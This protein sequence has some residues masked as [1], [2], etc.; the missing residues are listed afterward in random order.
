M[1]HEIK[2]A[3]FGFNKHIATIEDFFDA[4]T[5]VRIEQI[6]RDMVVLKNKRYY[7]IK[8]FDELISELMKK[9]NEERD[10]KQCT[11]PDDGLELDTDV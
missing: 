1:R 7:P 2:C 4:V 8:L 11:V 10:G 6:S 9:L 3:G 5:G